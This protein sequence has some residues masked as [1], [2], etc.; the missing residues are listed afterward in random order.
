MASTKGAISNTAIRIFLQKVGR[1]YD[2]KRGFKPL[3]VRL[4]KDEKIMLLTYFEYQCCYCGTK[5]NISNISRDHLIPENRLSLGLH[6]WGNVVPCCRDCN[7]GKNKKSWIT[8]LKTKSGI[9]FKNRKNKIE[10]FV[11][12]MKYDP[13]LNL[14]EYANNLY[15]DVGEVAMTLINLRYNQA[16]EDIEK[17]LDK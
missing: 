4:N 16:I 2:E 11:K 1:Y 10:K 9:D 7:E 17:L 12:D 3:T 13:N 14:H 5:I 8:F 15:Q 6:A